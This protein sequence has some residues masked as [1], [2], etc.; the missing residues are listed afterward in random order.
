MD[1]NLLENWLNR[2]DRQA[3]GA[4]SETPSRIESESQTE[5]EMSVANRRKWL[6]DQ[7]ASGRNANLHNNDGVSPETIREL[8]RAEE[9]IVLRPKGRNLLK[10]KISELKDSRDP[11]IKLKVQV[12]HEVFSEEWI[13]TSDI[14]S[15][16]SYAGF[17]SNTQGMINA[18]IPDY[19]SASP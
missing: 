13:A 3:K 15:V 11:V 16:Q 5:H 10:C 9:W 7:M 1:N 12:K 8:A 17:L 2:N 19:D 4:D 6:D 18:I 14:A